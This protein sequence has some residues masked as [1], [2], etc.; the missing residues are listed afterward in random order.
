MG[1]YRRSISA[2]A[3]GLSLC[4]LAASTAASQDMH[5]SPSEGLVTFYS[6]HITVLGGIPGHPWGAFKGRLFD[7]GDQLA[8]MEPAHFITFRVVPGMHVFT[9]DSWMNKHSDHGAHITMSVQ[10][11]HRYF[12]ETGSF[13]TEPIFGIREVSCQFAQGE[14]AD[15]KPLE[16]VHFLPAGK[17]MALPETSFP[18]CPAGS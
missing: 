7:G 6:N 12:I 8:F 16:S 15:L 17:L 14:G 9:A 2:A 11:G 10:A 1:R 5:D 3:F 13:A 4:F 18:R